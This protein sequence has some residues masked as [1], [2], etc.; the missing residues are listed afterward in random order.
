MAADLTPR[1]IESIDTT[2]FTRQTG[3]VRRVTRV[4]YMLGD[5]G[6]FV[7]DVDFDTFSEFAL[8]EAMERKAAAL[9]NFA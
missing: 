7:V 8:R 3:R 2:I 4:T 6:P 5:L 9:R 1:V